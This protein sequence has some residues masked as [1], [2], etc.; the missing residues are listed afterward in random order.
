M[1]QAE[2]CPQGYRGLPCVRQLPRVQLG[3]RLLQAEQAVLP[4]TNISAAEPDIRSFWVTRIQIRFIQDQIHPHVAS[5]NI[6]S[7]SLKSVEN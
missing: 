7:H 2:P 1:L 4:G 5:I 3:P 6:C